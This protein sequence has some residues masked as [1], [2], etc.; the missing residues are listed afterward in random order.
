MDEISIYG[1]DDGHQLLKRFAAQYDVPAYVRRARQVQEEF[2]GL[3]QRCRRQRDEWLRLPRIRL[4]LLRG[5]AGGWE[6]LQPL[7][8]DGT[9]LAILEQLH[10][11]LRP[12]LRHVVTRTTSLRSLRRVL[13]ELCESL[14][15]YNQRWQGFLARVDLS[16]VNQLRDGYNRY[17]LLEKEC[18]MRS[19]HLARQGFQRLEPLT[20]NELFALLPLL[21]I[22]QL[23]E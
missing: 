2:D 22:P 8:A 6:P 4:G 3:V 1:R 5:M 23:K 18:A 21:P 7:L 13:R 11:A 9:Q 16:R 14:Q 15:L 10:D 20:L 19:P 12:Q 17:Y